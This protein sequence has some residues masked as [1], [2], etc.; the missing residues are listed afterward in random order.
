MVY[1]GRG[2]W[3]TTTNQPGQPSATVSP[4][5]GADSRVININVSGA[6]GIDVGRQIANVLATV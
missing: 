4:T 1:D 5:T 2:H 3:L 6:S